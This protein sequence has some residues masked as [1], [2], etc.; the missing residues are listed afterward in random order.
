MTLPA[1]QAPNTQLDWAP[2]E[3]ALSTYANTNQQMALRHF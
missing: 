2:L 1:F 3:N